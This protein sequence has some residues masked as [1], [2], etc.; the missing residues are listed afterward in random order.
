MF[1]SSSTAVIGILLLLI[2]SVAV[3]SI[4]DVAIARWFG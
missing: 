1:T 3:Y 4:W 2:L